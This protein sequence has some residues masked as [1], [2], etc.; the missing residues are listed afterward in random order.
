[1]FTEF[2][3]TPRDWDMLLLVVRALNEGHLSR[4]DIPQDVRTHLVP[5]RVHFDVGD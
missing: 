1:M 4:S 2:T 5:F 3:Y